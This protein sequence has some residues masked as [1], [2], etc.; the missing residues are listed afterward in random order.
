[1]DISE[2]ILT[3]FL[4]VFGSGSLIVAYIQYRYQK[5]QAI[6]EK[7]REERRK[8]Y[9]DLLSPFISILNSAQV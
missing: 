3:V 1:M 5:L 9:F 4:A 6:Q 2:I 8:I 7:L